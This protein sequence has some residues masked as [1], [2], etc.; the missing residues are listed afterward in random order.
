[1]QGCRFDWLVLMPSEATQAVGGDKSKGRHRVSLQADCRLAP[2]TG[3]LG[4]WFRGLRPRTIPTRFSWAW[5]RKYS[6][7]YEM[8]SRENVEPRLETLSRYSYCPP[9]S[10]YRKQIEE[11]FGNV[12]D[13]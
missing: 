12:Y 5:A 10:P 8:H 7:C 4:T 3:S 2:R 11:V 1:M 13:G 9:D 6:A